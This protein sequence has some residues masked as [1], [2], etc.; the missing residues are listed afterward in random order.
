[1]FGGH[2]TG[3]SARDATKSND[4]A[5]AIVSLERAIRI[6]PRNSELWTELAAAHLAQDQLAVAIQHARK[7]IA[8]AGNNSALAQKAW[9]TLADIREAEGRI[10]EAKSIR[11]RYSRI[12]G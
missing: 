3:A 5:G 4:H 2:E 12:S 6:T 9:L 1:M 8:L 10:N 11:R 7:A